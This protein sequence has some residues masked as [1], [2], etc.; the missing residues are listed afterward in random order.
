MKCPC[1]DRHEARQQVLQVRC[2][3]FRVVQS[4]EYLGLGFAHL[5]I[6][7]IQRQPRDQYQLLPWRRETARQ[8]PIEQRVEFAEN[9]ANL[10]GRQIQPGQTAAL[11]GHLLQELVERAQAAGG[12]RRDPEQGANLRRI[13]RTLPQQG[14]ELPVQPIGE[15]PDGRSEAGA[16]GGARR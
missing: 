12:G 7:L 14:A 10:A 2:L 8:R 13:V 4:E 6:G 16:S 15:G 5:V 9:L 1:E 3:G 11:I